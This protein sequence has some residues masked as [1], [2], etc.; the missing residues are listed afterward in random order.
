ME[1]HGGGFT[2]PECYG[3]VPA[4]QLCVCCYRMGEVARAEA[5]NEMACGIKPDSEPCRYN[6]A[7][8]DRLKGREPSAM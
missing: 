8:F 4:L 5:Y 3:Y 6:R 7:F 1:E 2:T